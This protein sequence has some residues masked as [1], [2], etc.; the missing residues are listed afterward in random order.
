MHPLWIAAVTVVVCLLLW[1][2]LPPILGV[3]A[4]VRQMRAM[5]LS[6]KE[7]SEA[8][9]AQGRRFLELSK[10]M[11]QGCGGD[12]HE[13]YCELDPFN[14]QPPHQCHVAGCPEREESED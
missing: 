4:Y 12:C 11:E 2:I 1:W 3:V 10:A 13:P 14:D 8:L 7:I 5:G 6:D 9:R